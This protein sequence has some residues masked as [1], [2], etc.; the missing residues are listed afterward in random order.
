MPQREVELILMR[1]WA[2]CLAHTT[3]SREI[4]RQP[5]GSRLKHGTA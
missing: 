4:Q 1:Q 2:S 5:S 3:G